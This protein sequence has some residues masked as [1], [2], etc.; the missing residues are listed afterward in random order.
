MIALKVGSKSGN[1]VGIVT[2]HDSDDIL[3]TSERGQAIR[4][5][6]ESIPFQGRSSGGVR[7]SRL[8]QGDT[9]SS[10]ATFSS[11]NQDPKKSARN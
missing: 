6:V 3:A 10:I 2:V 4:V 11:E 7:V 9:I 5:G 8:D 1:L